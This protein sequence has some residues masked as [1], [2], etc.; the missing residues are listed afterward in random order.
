MRSG[1][2]VAKHG[3]TL[4]EI[5]LALAIMAFVTSIM[6]GTFT[7]TA[8]VKKRI[9][10]AQD[11][12]HTVRVA[13]MRMSREIEMAFLSAS[14]NRRAR[15]SGAPCS[16]HLA[17]RLRRAALLVVRAPAPARRRRRGRHLAGQLLRR[18]RSRRLDHHQ[19]H[20]SRDAAAGGQGSQ[21]DPGRD[22]H[23][24][25]RTSRAS[26]S[27]TTTTSRRSGARSGTPPRP[28]G[29]STCP[30]T[31]ASRS[32]CSTSGARPSPSP[33]SR[34][35]SLEKVDYRPEQIL[36]PH[37]HPS[38]ALTPRTSTRAGGGIRAAV[39]AAPP[40]APQPRPAER[41]G[42]A[43]DHLGAVAADRLGVAVLLRHDRRRRAGR[44]RARRAA[45]PL[46]RALGRGAV[47]PAHQDPA[48]VRRAHHGPGA[49]DARP[50]ESTAR[51]WAS[52]CA[53]PTTPPC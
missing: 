25:A 43:G 28:T 10:A 30:R 26:S 37:V 27:P 46:P 40:R 50:D 51:I 29:S 38:Q 15:K 44:Q 2:A 45:R 47:A 49:D 31:S 41:G 21:A 14:E 12:T 1:P 5:M 16:R 3:F 32:P 6:W 36:R 4:I 7:Q 42:L 23:A 13:L 53:S 52:A 35:S 19:P 8:K 39:R 22:L 24:S 11:R 33:A 20:A 48:Q 18:A 17:Q 34:A 9:E